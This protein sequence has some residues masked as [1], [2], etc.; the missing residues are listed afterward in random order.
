MLAVITG[1]MTAVA[2]GIVEFLF[3][4][5]FK[6]AKLFGFVFTFGAIGVLTFMILAGAALSDYDKMNKWV[7]LIL[8]I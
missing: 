6:I 2:T 8:D 1:V 3:K 7:K 4:S 5:K